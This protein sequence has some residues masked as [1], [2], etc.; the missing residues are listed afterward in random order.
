MIA[1]DQK[2]TIDQ[3]G[4]DDLISMH[5]REGDDAGE[6]IYDLPGAAVEGW[7]WKMAQA[8]SM[9]S[10]TSDGQTINRDQYLKHCERMIEEY[11]RSANYSVGTSA[12]DEWWIVSS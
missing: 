8:A 1:W 2:P 5:S 3:A 12:R 10:F 11:G 9:I 4:I 6:V 7:K